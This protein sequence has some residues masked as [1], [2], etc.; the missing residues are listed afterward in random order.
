MECWTTS[1]NN[2]VYNS[3][4]ATQQ[5]N[6]II[7]TNPLL[8]CLFSLT[9][10]C[11]AWTHADEDDDKA[12]KQQNPIE[13]APVSLNTDIQKSSAIETITLKPTSH[14]AEFIAYGKVLNIQSLLALRH[15][16]L[17]ALTEQRSAQAKFKQSEQNTQRQQELYSS[18]V[19]SKRSLQEQQSQWQSNQAQVEASQYQNAAIMDEAQLLWGRELADWVTSNDHS[20]LDA[21]LSGRKKLIQVTLPT[22]QHLANTIRSID[23]EASGNRTK[24]HKAEFISAATH[25][26]LVAQGESYFFQ[27]NDKGLLPGMSISTWIPEQSTTST[28]VMIPKSALIWYMDQAIVYI[29]STDTTFSRRVL[30]HYTP[31]V[32]GY[33]VPDTLSP[34]QQ[35]VI[36]GAQMLLSEELRGQIPKEDDD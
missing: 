30:N 7:M 21:F 14:H 9:L 20:K 36:T 4:S 29:K 1:I 12:S 22:H 16:Y 23:I 34:N 11:S 3:T 28:G 18:G 26:D 2:K 6:F 27:S 19:S 15:R 25:T 5:L 10:L 31:T 24:A 13:Q 8:A 35:L 32:D 33:F 17:L